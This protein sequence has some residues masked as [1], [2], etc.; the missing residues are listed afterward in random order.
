M[1]VILAVAGGYYSYHPFQPRF[2][3]QT[4][5]PS[6][7]H[8]ATKSRRVK[9]GPAKAVRYRTRSLKW[10]TQQ[11]TQNTLILSRPFNRSSLRVGNTKGLRRNLASQSNLV[12]P[13]RLAQ[14]KHFQYVLISRQGKRL[15]WIKRQALRPT[16]QYLLPYVYTS[17][18]WPSKADDACEIASLKTALSTQNKAMNTSLR[19]M[20]R[21]IPRT[22]NPNRGYTHDPYKYGSHATIYPD[23]MVKIARRYGARAQ[24]IT[25]ASQQLFAWEVTHGR[26]VVFEGPYMM[27]KP[28]SDHDLTI[29]GYKPHYFYVVDPFA[30]YRDSPRAT[31]VSAARMI[32]LFNRSFRHQRALVVY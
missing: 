11:V 28:G 1:V 14:S 5:K 16:Q 25:G 23:A 19:Q 3:Q 29:M 24:N 8:A 22:R 27:R 26:T 30:R 2:N 4:A 32:K 18:F 12:Q 7:R 6:P 17:Q 15:G 20:V 9:I 21:R 31:W 10:P 13:L